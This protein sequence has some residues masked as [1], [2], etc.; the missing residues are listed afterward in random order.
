MRASVEIFV[1]GEFDIG[2]AARTEHRARTLGDR[3]DGTEI[4]FFW[5]LDEG[6][7]FRAARSGGPHNAALLTVA[8]QR[9]VQSAFAVRRR[10]AVKFDARANPEEQRDHNRY[11]E[12]EEDGAEPIGSQQQQV[13]E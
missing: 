1:R 12:R 7:A 11:E 13:E 9:H 6:A 3:A 10:V 8:A 2:A 4:Q 5:F